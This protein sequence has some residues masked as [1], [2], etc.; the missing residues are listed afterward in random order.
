MKMGA[1][2]EGRRPCTPGRGAHL[3]GKEGRARLWRAQTP[4]GGHAKRGA[5]THEGGYALKPMWA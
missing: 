5:R 4:G 2:M 1:R 3:R